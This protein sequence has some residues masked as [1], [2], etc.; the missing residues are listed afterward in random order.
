MGTMEKYRMKFE[1]VEADLDYDEIWHYIKR[2]LLASGK[3][4]TLEFG[5][6]DK[7]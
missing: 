1:E 5:N 7:L 4:E 2:K 3:L 6:T